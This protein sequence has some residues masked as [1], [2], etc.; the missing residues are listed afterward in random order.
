[1]SFFK[2][3]LS[4]ENH[5]LS[6]EDKVKLSSILK[7]DKK[8]EK[9]ENESIS[10]NNEVVETKTTQN[11]IELENIVEK[12]NFSEIKKLRFLLDKKEEKL[13]NTYDNSEQKSDG[14]E[15]ITVDNP[16]N[17]IG[18]I[19]IENPITDEDLDKDKIQ[20]VEDT[21]EIQQEEHFEIQEIDDINKIEEEVSISDNVD[22]E[23]KKDEN[24]NEIEIETKTKE[25]N[26][27][28][29]EE[30]NND[31]DEK[32]DEVIVEKEEPKIEDKVLEI[33]EDHPIT[34]KS[35]LE[36]IKEIFGRENVFE[37][38]DTKS[39]HEKI[40]GK[41]IQYIGIR[42]FDAFE[43]NETTLDQNAWFISNI[44]KLTEL[45]KFKMV[46]SNPSL[47]ELML[48]DDTNPILLC[49]K[50]SQLLKNKEEFNF[51]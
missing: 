19:E 41:N 28:I 5:E 51:D 48:E 49:Y 27:I 37:K 39:K 50:S 13:S 14:E 12:L 17:Q 34:E 47:K 42:K 24:L 22:K 31:I 23:P 20:D 3:F 38:T 32:K 36:K 15:Y 33:K 46:E 40:N 43:K 8:E 11:N 18:E 4:K 35:I 16:N 45:K 1:M 29:V 7:G 6:E 26:G 44:K 25:N 9:V 30:E 2:K 21:H 10:I